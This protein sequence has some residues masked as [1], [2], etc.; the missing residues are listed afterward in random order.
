MT[1]RLAAG[2]ALLAAGAAGPVGA[3]DGVTLIDQLCAE[4]T[5]CLSGDT[6]GFPV[7]LGASGSYRLSSAL[8]V[9]EANLAAIEVGTDDVTIDLNGFEITG[10]VTCT[11]E[12]PT[13]SCTFFLF[14][15]KG[16]SA[17]SRERV[18]VRNGTVRGFA[19]GGVALGAGGRVLDLL[20]EENGSNGI[21]V[22]DDSLVRRSLA[23]R[24]DGD[25]VNGGQS[26]VVDRS[27]AIGNGLHGISVGTNG[28]V[29]GCATGLNGA[30]GIRGGAAC[31]VHGSTGYSNDDDGIHADAGCR[32]THNATTLNGGDGI[33]AST[34]TSLQG[35]T[36]SGNGAYG[37]DLAGSATYRENVLSSTNSSG[38]VS[39]GTNLGANVC[40]LDLICP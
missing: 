12:G 9:S 35:N 36:A 11:G 30:H 39:G 28:N 17:A 7:S 29:V 23:L 10:P 37:F 1:H 3:I 32:I 21:A 18:A 33:R 38:T 8:S 40:G 25:G 19:L 4:Q 31:V 26:A 13:L 16:I 5:G 22:G 24:N 15:G 27:L 20:V 34:D 14:P 6:P 2:L